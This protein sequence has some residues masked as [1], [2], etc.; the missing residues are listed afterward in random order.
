MT[1]DVHRS[2]NL[3]GWFFLLLFSAFFLL[4]LATAVNGGDAL[5]GGSGSCQTYDDTDPAYCIPHDGYAWQEE[6]TTD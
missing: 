6:Y 3:W 1:Y 4:A 2:A 5:F